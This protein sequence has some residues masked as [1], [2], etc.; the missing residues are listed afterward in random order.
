MHA[1]HG[2]PCRVLSRVPSFL[3]HFLPS[4]RRTSQNAR[5]WMVIGGI[6]TFVIYFI[7]AMACGFT[8]SKC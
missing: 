1:V 6:V 3:L 5:M 8:F 7:V 2:E 4:P